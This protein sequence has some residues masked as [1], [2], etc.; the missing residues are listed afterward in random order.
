MDFSAIL[1]DNSIPDTVEFELGGQKLTL[2]AVRDLSKRQQ[3]QLSDEMERLTKERNEVKELATKAAELIANAQRTQPQPQPEPTVQNTDDWNDPWYKPIKDHLTPLEKQM[4]EAQAK[5]AAQEQTL[6]KAAM[7]LAK[8]M[9]R[10][11]YRDVKDRL[12]GDKYKDYRDPDKLADYAAK[13]NLID[14][15]GFPSVTRA[16]D[17][18]TREDALEAERKKAYEEGIAKGR[19]EGRMGTMPK[20]SSAAGAKGAPSKGLDPGKNFEDLGDSVSEDPEL[21]QMLSQIGALDV[22]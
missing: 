12:K 14:E 13:H 17:E 8:R 3:K 18:L 22:Q 2:G 20:P 11:D 10:E 21:M 6:Q 9:F 7:F 19:I 1:A 5:L 4:Q 16:V 15:M